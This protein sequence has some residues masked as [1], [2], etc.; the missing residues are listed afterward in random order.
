MIYDCFTFFNE[1]DLLE[2]RLNVLDGVVDKFVLVESVRTHQGNSKPLYYDENKV[3]FAKF[4]HKIVHIVSDKF[5]DGMSASWE[6]ERYQRNQIKLGL[7]QCKPDD[8][9]IISDLDEIP[10]PDKI[11]QAARIK[12]IKIFHQRAFNYFLNCAIDTKR[13]S[14][15]GSAMANYK[16]FDQPQ[17]FRNEVIRD[18]RL[19]NPKKVK[20]IVHG[21][22]FFF[23]NFFIKIPVTLIED[24]GWHFSY[25]GGTKKII[26]KLEAFAHTEFNKEQYKNEQEIEQLINQGKSVYGG[27]PL[28][29]VPIDETFPIYIQQNLDRFAHHIKVVK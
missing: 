5:P 20:R 26:Q 11:H 14:W 12:G 18:A 8:V 24:G 4:A 27:P 6:Y 9:I 10:A 3:R 7:Q 1:L 22:V 25:L 19:T 15:I 21:V 28:T 13:S 16:D 29:F 23:R 2:I 17:E